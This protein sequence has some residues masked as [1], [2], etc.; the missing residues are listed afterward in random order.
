MAGET[1]GGGLAMRLSQ[2][3]VDLLLGADPDQAA[4]GWVVLDDGGP[5]VARMARVDGSATLALNPPSAAAR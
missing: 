4:P 2:L 1:D 3:D 5:H